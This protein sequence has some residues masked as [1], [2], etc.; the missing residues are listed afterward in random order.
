MTNICEVRC[1]ATEILLLHESDGLR[2]YGPEL[3][4]HGFS[5]LV[6]SRRTAERI[7]QRLVEGKIDSAV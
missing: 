4:E 7:R 6:H 1:F 5:P 2:S 3:M